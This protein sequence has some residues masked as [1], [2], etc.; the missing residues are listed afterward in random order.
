MDDDEERSNKT[1][2]Y[3]HLLKANLYWLCISFMA[4]LP[5][6]SNVIV[7]LYCVCVC[8]CVYMYVSAVYI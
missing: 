1:K 6:S 2:F 5:R 3:Q 4:S 8:V 7:L